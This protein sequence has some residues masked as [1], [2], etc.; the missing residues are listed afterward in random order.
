[1]RV[2]KP[3]SKRSSRTEKKRFKTRLKKQKKNRYTIKNEKLERKKKR[4]CFV[5]MIDCWQF[6]AYFPIRRTQPRLNN[7]CYVKTTRQTDYSV[8]IFFFFFCRDI[9]WQRDLHVWLK[10]K[11]MVF[12][13]LQTSYIKPGQR[14]SIHYDNPHSKKKKRKKENNV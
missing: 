4:V 12:F 5:Q 9:L 14:R 11:I 8:R 1:M 13:S 6:F 10:E 2:I 7:T 3:S